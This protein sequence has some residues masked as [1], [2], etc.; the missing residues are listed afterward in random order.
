MKQPRTANKNPSV[1]YPSLNTE[2]F[3][4]M[5]TKVE[6]ENKDTAAV[7][8]LSINRYERKK[9]IELAIK[10]F[11]RL[12]QRNK[13]KVGEKD[14]KLIIA[15]GY[16]QNVAE[17]IQYYS[18]LRKMAEEAGISSKVEFLKSPNEV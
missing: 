15:G 2:W 17:N 12:L 4:D 18:E 6:L 3:D 13:G 5:A 14:L 10:A 8:F 7:T 1:L 16:D 11:E 9:N